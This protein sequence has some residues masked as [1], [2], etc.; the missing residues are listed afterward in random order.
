MRRSTPLAPTLCCM[1]M[2]RIWRPTCSS[3]VMSYIHCGCRT[4][5]H[6]S[7]TPLQAAEWNYTLS[8]AHR[9]ADRMSGRISFRF[10][11][12]ANQQLNWSR[13]LA[14]HRSAWVERTYSPQ[15]RTDV[16]DSK[17]TCGE[18]LIRSSRRRAI[19]MRAVSEVSQQRGESHPAQTLHQPL[20]RQPCR[21]TFQLS[22]ATPH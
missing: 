2:L 10:D 8:A 13:R 22:F 9:R 14:A 20:S 19:S 18:S 4:D 16:N 12:A 11:G 7:R 1:K 21:S 5:D 15:A 3:D 6:T 17:A